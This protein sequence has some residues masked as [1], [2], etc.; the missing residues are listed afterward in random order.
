VLVAALA[1]G[2]W[3]HAHA[4]EG[5][6]LVPADDAEPP[7][8]RKPGAASESPSE[9]YEHARALALAGATEAALAAFDALLADFPDDA[10]YLLGRAQMQARLG[11]DS[12]AVLTAERALAL[13]PDYE[14]VWRLRLT[15]AERSGDEA[16]ADALR[17]EVAALFPAA[18]WWQRPPAQVVHRRSISAGFGADRLSNGA[19]DWSR[20]FLRVDW[21]LAAAGTVF[22][23]VSRSERFEEA[24]RSV[25][26][27]GLWNVL[28]KWQLGAAW[29]RA[30]EPRF[31]PERELSLDATRAWPRGWGTTIG[32]RERDYATGGGVSSYSLTG[33]KYV[34]DYRIAYRL[35]RSRLSG[36][37]SALTHSV[38]FSWYASDRRT[39]GVTLGAGEE[40]ET[41]GL[42]QLLRTSV[43]NVTLTGSETLS[44]RLSLSWW[45]GTHEQ[46]DFYRRNYAGL[47]IRIG[48]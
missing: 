34:A 22:A 21:Q 44:Q 2:W 41:I 35:D 12:A 29:G 26:A 14:D 43:A 9:R 11:Q 3:P 4:Q 5:P 19:P 1:G 48:L 8:E 20:E 24:D 33:E 27:G 10:D 30:A 46:G 36:A 15:L 37:E 17:A 45:V 39:L 13:A 31:L 18:T 16:S 47:S 28:P 38:A 42:D 7:R 25:Y 40:I 32:V 23:E 6:A